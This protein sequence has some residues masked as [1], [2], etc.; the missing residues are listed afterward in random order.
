M[1]YQSIRRYT[2]TQTA[3]I[4]NT[5]R[6]RKMKSVNPFLKTVRGISK[7]TY[8]IRASS[9]CDAGEGDPLRYTIR[10]ASCKTKAENILSG[11]NVLHFGSLAAHFRF[12]SFHRP[13]FEIELT[14]HPI[15]SFHLSLLSSICHPINYDHIST[16]YNHLLHSL[17]LRFFQSGCLARI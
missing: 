3:T 5:L 10:T 4:R 12:R 7:S 13:S 17:L 6:S 1:L 14:N 8:I 2:H 11:R 9:G 16:I 15:P